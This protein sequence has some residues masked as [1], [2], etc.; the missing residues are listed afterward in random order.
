MESA[1]W[2]WPAVGLCSMPTPAA[3]QLGQCCP[4]AG[5]PV[6]A[7]VPAEEPP[8]RPP[9]PAPWRLSHLRRNR[10][11]APQNKPATRG[12]C[13]AFSGWFKFCFLVCF[14]CH[15]RL[16]GLFFP[17]PELAQMSR[18]YI[19]GHVAHAHT[20][21]QA[22][23]A[24]SPARAPSP[25]GECFAS[26]AA[27]CTAHLQTMQSPRISSLIRKRSMVLTIKTRLKVYI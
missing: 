5:G 10:R 12:V 24:E 25:L 20:H 22:P 11:S 1:A 26:R 7:G 3:A 18:F 27:F 21:P 17:G 4:Q 23:A 19:H 13:L 2:G 8:A 16:E 9:G 15:T 6:L 14:L